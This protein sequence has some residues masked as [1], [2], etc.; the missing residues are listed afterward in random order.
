VND[1]VVHEEKSWPLAACR[2]TSATVRT[3]GLGVEHVQ[4]A[5]RTWRT[6]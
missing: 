3:H 4:L 1:A 6:R 2:E 5:G